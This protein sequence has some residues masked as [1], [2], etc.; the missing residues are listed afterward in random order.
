MLGALGAVMLH[1]NWFHFPCHI[2][3]IKSGFE[4]TQSQMHS[5]P[6][7][8][9][10][11]TVSNLPSLSFSPVKWDTMFYRA[12]LALNKIIGTYIMPLPKSWNLLKT[13]FMCS[14]KSTVAMQV[15]WWSDCQKYFY[16]CVTIA[17][18]KHTPN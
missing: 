1:F 8:L 18:Q 15:F 7:C 16:Y 4:G 11:V 12:C 14:P 6:C 5:W 2:E 9:L 13:G 3:I 10:C 17:V